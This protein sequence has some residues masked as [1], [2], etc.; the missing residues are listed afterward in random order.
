MNK[1][2]AREIIR[3]AVRRA[4]YTAGIDFDLL[5]PGVIPLFD[6]I[7]AHPLRV[8]EL[9][10]TNL[11]L[12]FS[13]AK[14]FISHELGQTNSALSMDDSPLSGFLYAHEF[15]GDFYGVVLTEKSDPTTRRRYSAAHELGHYLLHFLP[16]LEMRLNRAE[17]DAITWT[18]GL[19]FSDGSE[20]NESTFI[21]RPSPALKSEAEIER[22]ANIFAAE[23]LMPEHSCR[24]F[25]TH[26]QSQF[27]VNKTAMRRKMAG[28][29]LVSIEAMSHR[30]DNLGL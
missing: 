20:A 19:S 14:H 3:D 16:L 8:A 23:L 15:A 21:G 11:R 1:T 24:A 2:E 5:E 22:E 28:E 9:P 12:R 7:T 10:E 25:A 29:F 13:T 27:K 6:I 18:E 4:C 17:T 30:L 26:Y